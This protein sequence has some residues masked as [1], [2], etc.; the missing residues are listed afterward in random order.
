MD[1]RRFLP[2]VYLKVREDDSAIEDRVQANLYKRAL[3]LIT[4]AAQS[5]AQ[6]THF[7]NEG[8]DMFAWVGASRVLTT[9]H[10]IVT[11][12][13]LLISILPDDHREPPD[14]SVATSNISNPLH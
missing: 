8:G 13:D 6:S 2:H 9:R 12:P 5:D 11:K 3:R 1:C 4:F 10:K 7:C 14:R